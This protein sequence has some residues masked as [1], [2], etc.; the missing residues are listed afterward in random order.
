VRRL[1]AEIERRALRVQIEVDGGVDV[2]NAR[3]LQEA[4]AD[5]LVV[6]SA[7][8]A[9]GDPEGAARRLIEICR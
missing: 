8:F 2:G 6:G 4:G 1:R 7:V 3:A 5:V 9:G